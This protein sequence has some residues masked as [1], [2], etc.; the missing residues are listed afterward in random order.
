MRSHNFFPLSLLSTF[1]L[2]LTAPH[3]IAFETEAAQAIIYDYNTQQILR[4]KAADERMHP[5][6]MSKLM[7]L[8]LLFKKLKE[9]KITLTDSFT[10]S[11]KAWRMGGSRMFL[12]LGSEVTVEDLIRGIVVQSGNDACVVVAEGLSGSEEAFAREMNTAAHALGLQNSHFMN[13]SG[14]PD[15]EHYMT[16]HDL[17][18]LSWHLIHDFPEY[19]P[20][21]SEETY[22][23]NGITQHNRNR[24]LG[25]KMN[26]DGLKTGHTEAG[27]Y[28]IVLSGYDPDTGRRVIS[29][30]NGLK[31]DN[32]RLRAGALLI[33]DGLKAF[34]SRTL[35][36]AEQIVGHANV[37][38]GEDPTVTL[39][40]KTTVEAVIEK[41][42][43]SE[44]DMHIRYKGPVHAPIQLGEEI[45]SLVILL[46][47]GEVKQV[48]LFA[49]EAVAEQPF[50]GRVISNL[51][52]MLPI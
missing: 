33:R 21:F 27:G 4:A 43:A 45:A 48:P 46:P 2:L 39:M 29:V 52:H 28:G 25:G 41:A 26:I 10:V 34:E 32:A 8:Y 44:I 30:V 42:Q 49:A 9:E 36:E 19:Y 18:I 3:A 23:Y 14:W 31:D 11:E 40:I 24:V 16:A 37:W 50:F 20:Y 38:Q 1:L 15:E 17:A 5:S 35:I 12:P 6:S 13:A 51:M 22:T 7:T 47:D